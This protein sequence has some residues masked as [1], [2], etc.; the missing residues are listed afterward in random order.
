M[1]LHGILSEYTTD[2]INS[3]IPLID[4]DKF[5]RATSLTLRAIFSDL[6]NETNLKGAIECLKDARKRFELIRIGLF[7]A[8]ACI[9][10]H[11]NQAAQAPDEESAIITGKF[12][13]D[14]V[15]LLMY[16]TAEDLSYFI[17]HLYNIDNIKINA[18]LKKKNLVSH[19]SKVGV[20]LSKN[21][22]N[23]KITAIV[24]Q[25]KDDPDW[26]NVLSYRD[27]WVHEKPPVLYGSDLELTRKK[28][29]VKN[30]NGTKTMYIAGPKQEYTIDQLLEMGLNA[31]KALAL[32]LSSILEVLIEEREK[33]GIAVNIDKG[34]SS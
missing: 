26:S 33:M 25:L 16:A 1:N 22:P 6:S 15:M 23:D 10:W 31:T 32:A 2:Q 21:M 4:E 14:Y 3:K 19:A 7:E 24:L 28:L 18:N 29:I 20:Y 11:R 9:T 34:I 8:M 13:L 12:Y 5:S 30:D 17:T 27:K